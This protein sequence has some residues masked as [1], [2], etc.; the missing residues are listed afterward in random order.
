MTV[1]LIIEC[2]VAVL[3]I[4]TIGY[5]VV[6]NR[7]LVRLR[8]D[9]STLKGTIA[10]LVSASERAERAI[11]GL[12]SSA[13]T[14]ET[15]LAGRL[16]EAEALKGLLAREVTAGEGVLRRIAQITQAARVDEP[17]AA[18]PVER[19]PAEPPARIP[20]HRTRGAAA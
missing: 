13:E 20:F 7:R 16:R 10:E 14:A 5:C 18:S 12:K 15:T 11:A 3:L 19:A 1:S 6:L 2:L 9:E 8:S 4:T 17:V